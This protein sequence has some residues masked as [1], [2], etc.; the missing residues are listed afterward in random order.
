MKDQRWALQPARDCLKELLPD[1]Y[2]SICQ[3]LFEKEQERWT[4]GR[5]GNQ[6]H[7]F[8]QRQ[9]RV[10]FIIFFKKSHK[11]YFKNFIFS[12]G[13]QVT[14]FFFPSDFEVCFTQALTEAVGDQLQSK[15]SPAQ[16]NKP[17]HPRTLEPNWSCFPGW[18][19]GP[20]LQRPEGCVSLQEVLL[21]FKPVWVFVFIFI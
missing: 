20:N 18:A 4:A 14:F 8:T 2:D 1:S 12:F 13:L 7:S 15:E 10:L 3:Q 6:T 9:C 5:L 21:L 19:L 11:I 16:L 17:L